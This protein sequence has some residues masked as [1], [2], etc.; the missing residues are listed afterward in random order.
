MQM[1]LSR[2]YDAGCSSTADGDERAEM[3]SEQA[4]CPLPVH[5]QTEVQRAHGPPMQ[6]TCPVYH[7]ISIRSCLLLLSG[8]TMS[9]CCMS[10]WVGSSQH[11][12]HWLNQS[13]SSK[14]ITIAH[15]DH[16]ELL[17]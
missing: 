2:T 13:S 8:E 15:H 3:D 17:V 9:S 1:A 12:Q 4:E 14:C 6:V 7:V 10:A 11:A 5:H 16:A